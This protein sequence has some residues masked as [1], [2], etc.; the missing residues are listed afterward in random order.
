MMHYFCPKINLSKKYIR[1]AKTYTENLTFNY[2]CEN[3]PNYF[4]IISF[5]TTQLLC[6]FSAQTLYTFYKSSSSKCK[7]SDFPLLRVKFTKFVILFSNQKVSSSSKFGSIFSV[8][9]ENSSVHFQLKIYMLLTKVAHQSA[10]FQTF[11]CSHEN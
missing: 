8:M 10:N 1:S 5:F 6:I 4:V 3:S 11:N 2:S 9:R 7:F